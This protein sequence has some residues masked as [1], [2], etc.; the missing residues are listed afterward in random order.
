M[1][2]KERTVASA[3]EKQALKTFQKSHPLYEEHEKAPKK[4]HIATYV[5]Y[6]T[7]V[8]LANARNLLNKAIYLTKKRKPNK[9]EKELVE[10]L[11]KKVNSYPQRANPVEEVTF[12]PEEILAA[13]KIGKQNLLETQKNLQKLDLIISKFINVK[14]VS[15]S[16]SNNFPNHFLWQGLHHANRLLKALISKLN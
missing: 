4:N 14:G 8:E 10:L 2:P 11:I 3:L 16:R 15:F 5:T 1:H 12:T 9:N 7:H 13:K 6:R